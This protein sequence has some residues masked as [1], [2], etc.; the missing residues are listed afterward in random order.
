MAKKLYRYKVTRDCFV[1][2]C[3]HSE[4]QAFTSD[5]KIIHPCLV[6]EGE[7]TVEEKADSAEEEAE[8]AKKK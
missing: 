7:E 5:K 4:G 3:Y 6:L 8:P 1:R 2:D